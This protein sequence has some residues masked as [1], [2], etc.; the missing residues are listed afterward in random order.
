MVY[1]ADHG[2]SLG[3]NNL[4]LHGMP[5]AIAP[6]VQKRV[7][8]VTWMSPAWQRESGVDWACLASRRDEMLTHD[9]YFHS[10][11]G[12]MGVHTRVYQRT[13]D[14][15]APCRAEGVASARASG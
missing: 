8:W 9:G 15:Y 6:E 11:L 5:Y 7:P 14:A 13:L 1:V 3:E 12:L 4:Y 2:E 10:V